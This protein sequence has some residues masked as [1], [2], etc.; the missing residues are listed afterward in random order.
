MTFDQAKTRLIELART[1]DGVVTVSAVEEDVELSANHDIVS[2][3]AHAL[4]GST[5][6]FA[7]PSDSGWF[8]Y[9]EIRIS[10]LR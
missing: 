9:S 10:D 6:V 4:A 2:A 3:A 8:P 5:N 1:G 7:S